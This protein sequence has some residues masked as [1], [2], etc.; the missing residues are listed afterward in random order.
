MYIFELYIEI[1]WLIV[2]SRSSLDSI[3]YTLYRA[4]SIL[5]ANW[6]QGAFTPLHVQSSTYNGLHIYCT[7]LKGPGFESGKSK[8]KKAKLS[9]PVGNR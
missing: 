3:Q 5:A 9:E 7:W 2:L 4:M 6:Q 8:R 1:Y